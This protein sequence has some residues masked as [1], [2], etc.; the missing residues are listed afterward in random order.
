MQGKVKQSPTMTLS[1]LAGG[2][3]SVGSVKRL[4]AVITAKAQLQ[5]FNASECTKITEFIYMCKVQ[6]L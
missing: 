1:P 4:I 3:W 2:I 5:T 6:F